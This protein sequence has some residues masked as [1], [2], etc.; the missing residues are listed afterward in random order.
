M[1]CGVTAHVCGCSDAHHLLS[2]NFVECTGGKGTRAMRMG[3]IWALL[4]R[5]AL[6][7][8]VRIMRSLLL[9]IAD[10]TSA[11]TSWCFGDR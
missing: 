4:G 7:N 3:I 5:Y 10:L 11:M 9:T 2:V 8:H 1:R 6:L